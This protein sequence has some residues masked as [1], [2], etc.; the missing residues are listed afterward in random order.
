VSAEDLDALFQKALAAH[1]AGDE[2]MA[3]QLYLDILTHRR[4]HPHVW[5]NLAVI[6]R[7][8]RH[9]QS[10][11]A[12]VFKAIDVGGEKIVAGHN[13]LNVLLS[14]GR[15]ED[16][17]RLDMMDPFGALADT[18]VNDEWRGRALK[19]LGRPRAAVQFYEIC[20][21]HPEFRGELYADLAISLLAAG[22]YQDGWDVYRQRWKMKGLSKPVFPMPEWHGQPLDGKSILV[23]GEQGLGDMI[24][25]SRFLPNLRDRGPNRMVAVVRKPLVA[26]YES[27]G[28]FDAVYDRDAKTAETADYWIP[29]F[30]LPYHFWPETD[31]PG[32]ALA[33]RISQ[34]AADRSQR[35]LRSAETFFKIGIVWG[36]SA[37][38]QLVTAKSFD[39]SH[40]LPLSE[41]PTVQLVNLYKGEGTDQIKAL[42]A[43]GLILD[44]AQYDRHL[45]D[46]AAIIKDLDLVISVDTVIAHLA[47]SQTKPVWMLTPEP[48]FWYWNGVGER[49]LH[50]PTMRVIR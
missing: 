3:E 39:L 46:T 47:A 37:T 24:W 34:D 43:E 19:A 41:L 44:A 12:M 42:G 2:K 27:Y 23:A 17:L 20:M 49:T 4:D 35:I 30:D 8:Q 32:P 14:A 13:L 11:A 10:A 6:R 40:L 15:A 26:L 45:L 31:R 18:R 50:Y 48:A 7:A 38:S 5:T 22:R 28:L 33:P 9:M 25:L 36:S 29:A 16:A 21:Q 1:Q